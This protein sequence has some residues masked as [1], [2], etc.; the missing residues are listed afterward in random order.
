MPPLRGWGGAGCVALEEAGPPD[1][2]GRLSLHELGVF[3]ALC[4]ENEG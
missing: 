3:G 4:G 2:R 1:S